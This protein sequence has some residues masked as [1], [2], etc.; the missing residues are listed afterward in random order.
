MASYALITEPDPAR[1]AG[2]LSLL[3]AEGLEGATA[4]D[5]AEAQEVV[6][7]RGAPT[8][9]VT[10]LV[11][12]RVDGFALLSWLRERPDSTGTRV[13]VVTAFDELRVRAWQLK[14][15]L[16]IEA[17]LSRRA[18]PE[19]VRDTVRRVLAGQRATLPAPAEPAPE[20]EHQRLARIDAM[21]LVDEGP[22]EAELQELVS[23]VAQAFGVP[24]ALLSLVLG[25]RQWFKAHV[26]LP[27]SLAKAR[28]TPRDWSFCHH[29][30]QGHESL[31]VPDA[32]RHPVFRDNPLVRDG[33]VGSYAGAPLVTSAGEVLG[34]LC[35]ID[36]RPLVL[37]AEDLA[38]L[39]E[40]ARRVAGDLEQ[41]ARARQVA[42]LALPDAVRAEPSLTEA[43]ALA[44]LADAVRALEAPVLL[45]APGRRPHA[46][47]AALAD[48]LGLPLER[49]SGLTFEAFCQHVAGLTADP[50]LTL[51]QLDLASESSRGFRLTLALER[52]RPR[53][54][55]WV[56]R[57][58]P[59]PGGVAQMLTL[60]D[61]G[62][63]PSARDERERPSRVDA[64]TGLDTRRVGEERLLR[65][66]GR[67]R[68][69]GVP[70]GV[71]LVD[72]VELGRLNAERGF[73]AGDAALRDVA[74]RLA[75]LVGTA[76]FAVR[77]EGGTLLAVLPGVDAAGT[78][79][80]RHRL[81]DGPGA[82]EVVSAAVE[83]EGEEDPRGTLARAQ[84]ALARAKAA[85]RATRLG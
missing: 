76:G 24:V 56:A 38:A 36:T 1:A 51:R 2:L 81:Q 53:R 23:E 21:R 60:S 49:L 27:P 44:V 77:W 80:V 48:V 66:I 45:V 7:Q 25:D 65:E 30:V 79:A 46:G 4:R 74:R 18:S 33:I 42:R 11:L 75:D 5:G 68:R 12:P 8:L 10:D 32:A 26:G 71:L 52:P 50:A 9:L 55:R 62:G 41:R 47:N 39:R 22:P 15:V 72:W 70:C 78:E 64:L 35:V 17:L 28:Q 67:C 54:L 16:G 73:D 83:V 85:H 63:A 14:D 69:D 57:P 59:V 13:V 61:V 43:A 6:R 29:V 84:A 37:G 3:A 20:H 31:V 40:L 82:P 34:S 19:L 58:F